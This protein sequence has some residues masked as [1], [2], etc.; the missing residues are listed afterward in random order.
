MSDEPSASP[1]A[2]SRSTLRRAVRPLLLSLVA[3]VAIYLA[4]SLAA[5]YGD[6]A[7]SFKRIGPAGWALLLA[8]S[9]AN[10]A[11]LFLRWQ[12]CLGKPLAFTRL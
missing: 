1:A 8:L 6:V 5:G 3:G 7:L 11:I 10:C 12:R 2:I 9:L 4:S